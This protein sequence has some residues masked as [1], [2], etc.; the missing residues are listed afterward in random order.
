M[1]NPGPPPPGTL[2]QAR[3]GER[4]WPGEPAGHTPVPR[5][6]DGGPAETRTTGREPA[7]VLGVD[8][9]APLPDITGGAVTRAWLMLRIGPAA[10]GDLLL[11]VPA[12]GLRGDQIGAAI[13]AR[14]GA[15]RRGTAGRRPDDQPRSR[16][17][18]STSSL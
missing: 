10:V 7:L 11:P 9:R 17:R 1:M 8:L 6:R 18:G 15:K 2:P 5:L 4:P 14:M 16:R 13:A 12:E 3:S